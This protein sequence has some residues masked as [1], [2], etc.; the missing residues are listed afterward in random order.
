VSVLT[1]PP[2][3]SSVAAAAIPWS[4]VN[5]R[6]GIGLRAICFSDESARRNIMVAVATLAPDMISPRHKHTFEQLRYYIAGDTKFADQ[7]YEPGDCVY[8]PEGVAYGPQT[9]TPGSDCLHLALQW[10]GPAG[11][12][13]PTQ[14]EQRAARAELIAHGSFKGGVYTRPDGSTVDGFEALV[15]HLSGKPC[16]YPEPRYDRPIRMRSAAFAELALPGVAGAFARR[17]GF[18][19]ESGP[20]IARLRLEAGAEL[21]AG[22]AVGDEVRIVLSGTVRAARETLEGIAFL[23]EPHGAPKPALSAQTPAELLVMRYNIPID[24]AVR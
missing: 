3:P 7:V 24:S 8:F 1:A 2:G 15:E 18:F 19:N 17:L 11:I 12:Y 23:Y 6:E 13:Y 14:A 21:P 20:E 10:G 5:A 9:G 4:D 16:R 22:R